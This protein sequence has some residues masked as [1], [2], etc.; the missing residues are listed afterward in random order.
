MYTVISV[1]GQIP[2]GFTCLLHSDLQT[3]LTR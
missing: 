2:F 1:I 3:T